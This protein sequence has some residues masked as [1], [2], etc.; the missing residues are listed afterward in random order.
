MSGLDNQ[1]ISATFD[2]LL[3]LQSLLPLDSVSPQFICDGHGNQTQIKVSTNMTYLYNTTFNGP[4]TF[5]AGYSFSSVIPESSGGTGQSSVANMFNVYY[6]YARVTLDEENVPVDSDWLLLGDHSNSDLPNFIQLGTIKTYIKNSITDNDSSGV[7]WNVVTGTSQISSSNNGY[8][9]NN[10][11]LVT[12]TL[13]ITF[14]VGDIIEISGMNS[15][16]WKL[17]Q[18]IGQI[19][20]FNTGSTTTGSS[21]YLSSTNTRDAIRLIG[22]VANTELNVL[23]STGNITIV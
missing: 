9:T 1:D 16:G 12:I 8:L 21:G 20:H 23:S 13:P 3:T 6:P 22:V 7:T 15:G 18:N 17:A 5:A 4:I 2:S 10:S 14:S 11:S 19:I